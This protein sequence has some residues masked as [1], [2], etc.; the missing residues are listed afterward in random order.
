V[1]NCYQAIRRQTQIASETE[2]DETALPGGGH[3]ASVF[4]ADREPL[5]HECVSTV[6][7]T[8]NEIRFDP[9]ACP[10]GICF[11]INMQNSYRQ[12]TLKF[13]EKRHLFCAKP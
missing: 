1:L 8:Q 7:V 12:A 6:S 11:R 9:G 3:L 4:V 5:K 2:F 13:D 10:D